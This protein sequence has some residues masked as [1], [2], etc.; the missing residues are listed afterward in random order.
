MKLLFVVYVPVADGV[1][2][3][4]P[5]PRVTE[6]NNEKRK[7]VIKPL[8]LNLINLELGDVKVNHKKSISILIQLMST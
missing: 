1:T 8:L 2:F 7:I 6:V 5:S 3:L 4:E